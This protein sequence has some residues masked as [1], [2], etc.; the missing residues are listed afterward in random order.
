MTTYAFG[1]QHCAEEPMFA[2]YYPPEAQEPQLSLDIIAGRLPQAPPRPSLA[3]STLRPSLVMRPPRQRCPA[4]QAGTVHTSMRSAI[5]VPCFIY[6]Q[7]WMQHGSQAALLLACNVTMSAV[8]SQ[9][10]PA[11]CHLINLPDYAR[12]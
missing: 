7:L 8:A 11:I 2:K 12:H 6:T 9:Q 3:S 5:P 1:L 4:R 10:W